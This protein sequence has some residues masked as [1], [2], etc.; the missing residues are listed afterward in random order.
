MKGRSMEHLEVSQLFAMLVVMLGAA[1]S[2][3]PWLS[4][5][6]SPRFLGNWLGA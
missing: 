3:G 5:S 1:K 6:D 2:A 4:G